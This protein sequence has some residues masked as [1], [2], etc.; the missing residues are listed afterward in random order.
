VKGLDMMTTI[1]QL[2]S[3]STSVA[4]EMKV[5]TCLTPPPPAALCANS[6][7]SFFSSSFFKWALSLSRKYYLFLVMTLHVCVDGRKRRAFN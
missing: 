3:Q 5:G 2:M 6:G 7:R 1:A 4:L